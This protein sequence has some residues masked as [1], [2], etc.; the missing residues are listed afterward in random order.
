M[1]NAFDVAYGGTPTWDIGRPQAA[2]LRA[3]DAGLIRGRVLDAGCGTGE[4]ALLLAARGHSVV[5]VDLAP[6]A[7]GKSRAKAAARGVAAQFV[8]ADALGLGDPGGCI[9]AA[10]AGGFDTVLD[11]GLFHVLQPEDRRRY[12]RA[13]AAV[14]VPGGRALVLCWSSRNPFGYGP[15]RITRTTLRRSFV[16]ADGWSIERIEPEQLETL[17]PEGSVHAWLAV[18]HRCR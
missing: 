13:L 7:I 16:A 9:A 14:T 1:P 18:V 17:L 4:H 5:G 2:V 12:A 11:V 3:A 8:V 10:A 6:A 15:E